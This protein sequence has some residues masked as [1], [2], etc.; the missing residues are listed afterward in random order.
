MVVSAP[1]SPEPQQKQ[2]RPQSMYGAASPEHVQKSRPQSM[3]YRQPPRSQSRMS[4]S[5]KQG[6]SRA[7]DEDAKTAVRVGTCN[8][9]LG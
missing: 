6:A 2:A 4:Q 5:S 3:M 7:S 8:L 9:I 1:G